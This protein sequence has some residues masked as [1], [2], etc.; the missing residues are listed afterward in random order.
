MK[1]IRSGQNHRIYRHL[2]IRRDHTF[3]PLIWMAFGY[4]VGC[5]SGIFVAINADVNWMLNLSPDLVV[6]QDSGLF[7]VFCSCSVYFLGM[8]FLATS[9]FGFLLIPGV[10]SV[11][12]FLS[13]SVFTACIRGGAA[14][15]LEQACA[16]LFLPG[17]FLIPAML[18]LGQT[19][20]HW[21]V[22]LLRCRAGELI[23]PDPSASH[24]LGLALILLLMA[25]AVKCYAV[26]YILDLF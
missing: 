22:R 14:H 6:D 21:S 10:F 4:L 7:T 15:G 24:S 25:S 8:L 17:F 1:T 18:I 12:G 5:V 20:M 9:Y 2:Q 19:C 26:P 3:V 13:A 16:V 11:K 23:P